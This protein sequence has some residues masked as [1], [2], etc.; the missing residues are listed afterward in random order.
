VFK[1]GTLPGERYVAIFFWS[2]YIF[3]TIS[4]MFWK[5]DKGSENHSKRRVQACFWSYRIAEMGYSVYKEMIIF[6]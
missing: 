4:R 3:L 2:F 1:E 5:K 6:Q